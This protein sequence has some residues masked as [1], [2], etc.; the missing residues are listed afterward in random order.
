MVYF[1]VWWEMLIE[2]LSQR[3]AKLLKTSFLYY[4]SEDHTAAL[5]RKLMFMGGKGIAIL[6]KVIV[7]MKYE[8]MCGQVHDCKI[9]KCPPESRC[10]CFLD[11]NQ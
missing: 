2:K 10:V 3:N 8:A 6:N 4:T 1:G 5:N 7:E 9:S 11:L